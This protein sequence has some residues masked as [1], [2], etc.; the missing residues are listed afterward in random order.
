[1]GRP[2]GNPHLIFLGVFHGLTK[3]NSTYKL[4]LTSLGVNFYT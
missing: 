3:L 4:R 1:M 2:I